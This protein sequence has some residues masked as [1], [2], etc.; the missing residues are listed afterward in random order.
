MTNYETFS[1]EDFIQDEFFISWVLHPTRVEEEFWHQWLVDFPE[2][3]IYTDQARTILLAV[4]AHELE[5]ATSNQDVEDVVAYVNKHGYQWQGD[6][7]KTTKI[8]N[9]TWFRIA[10]MLFVVL[11][12]VLI[13]YTSADKQSRN[14]DLAGTG[15]TEFRNQTAQSRIVQ[16]GDGSLA[17]LKPNSVLKYPQTFSDTVREVFLT[18]EAFFEVRKNPKKPFLVHSKDIITKVLGTSFTVRAYVAEGKSSVIVNTGKVVVYTPE[19]NLEKQS[20]SV[21][22]LPHQQVTLNREQKELVKDTVESTMLLAKETARVAFS[23]DKAPMHEVIQK[24]ES[25]YNVKINYNSR[26][27]EDLTVTA[28]LSDLPLDEKVK[29]ICKAVGAS[30]S[31]NEGKISIQKN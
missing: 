17:V 5:S 10:A 28:S 18:G 14:T 19:R 12:V 24:L 1:P 20:N 27:L 22:L 23:F 8:W 25:A 31:F 29:L 4:R 3:K 26:Q 2:R 7:S 21:L 30:C 15:W 11:S 16:M 9:A 6:V 13:F